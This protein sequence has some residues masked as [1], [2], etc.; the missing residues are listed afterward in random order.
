MGHSSSGV[1]LVLIRATETV[2]EYQINQSSTSA[3]PLWP[4]LFPPT[5]G[6][7]AVHLEVS[8]VTSHVYLVQNKS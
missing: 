2:L 8:C 3:S 1:L 6:P 4:L 5:P 7:L